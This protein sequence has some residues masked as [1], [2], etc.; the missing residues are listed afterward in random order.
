VPDSTALTRRLAVQ[1]GA[2]AVGLLVA[3]GAWPR[4]ALAA[5]SPAAFAAPSYAQALQALGMALPQ[6][7]GAVSLMAPDIAD[8]SAA[9][10]LSASTTLAGARQLLILVEHNPA[11]LAALFHLSERVDANVALRVKMAQSST[12]YAVACAADGRAYVAQ[13]QVR[14]AQSGC[15]D[16][17]TT[18]EPSAPTG[19][20]QPTRI[21]AQAAGAL[22]TVRMLM[23]HAMES[24]Q[25]K[26][27][28]G[29]LVAAW[30]IQEVEVRLNDQ[31]VLMAQWGPSVAQNP[32][33]QFALKGA[34]PGDTL[35]VTWR[36][37]RG[38]SRS[39]AVKVS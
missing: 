36:D 2:A 24:G 14:V 4:L 29:Q 35:A 15:G 30:H 26:D 7:G 22:T 13:R 37:N 5:F 18:Q 28:A 23:S 11:P 6:E 16:A 1:G 27:A 8:N 17:G 10:S 34:Q 19:M 9:V 21:R 31:V 3:V 20:S 25:R 39:D 32:F 33:L 12:V 38:D